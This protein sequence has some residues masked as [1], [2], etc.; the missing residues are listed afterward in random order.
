[1]GVI[2]GLFC[3]LL[4]LAWLNPAQAQSTE[5]KTRKASTSAPKAQKKAKKKTHTVTH[6]RPQP[7]SLGQPPE[8]RT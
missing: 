5:P 6:K 1:M 8:R 2:A 3:L 4:S 7:R